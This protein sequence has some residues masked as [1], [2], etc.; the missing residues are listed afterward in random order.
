MEKVK[1]SKVC[2][3]HLRARAENS[4]SRSPRST[5][6]IIGIGNAFRGDDAVGLVVARMLKEKALPDVRIVEVSGEAASLIELWKDADSVIL[7]DAVRSGN[8]PGT[9][10]RLDGHVEPI[11]A[12]FLR[13]ST[14][15][16]GVAEAIELARTLNEL[17]SRLILYGIE[18][19][20]FAVGTGLSPEVEAAATDVAM[21]IADEVYRRL[22]KL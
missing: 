21:R 18:G 6:V 4:R 20:S 16:F 12:S 3:D 1:G 5:W 14:H 11:P 2:E 19:K 17:P 22:G 7:I 13:H 15:T 8:R 10:Y 9:V